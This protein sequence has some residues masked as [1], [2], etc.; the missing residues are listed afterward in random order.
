[1]STSEA[2]VS[3][4]ATVSKTVNYNQ[5]NNSPKSLSAAEIYRQTN[6]QLSRTKKILEDT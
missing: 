5:Y 4:A 1:M 2:D 3:A 6:N